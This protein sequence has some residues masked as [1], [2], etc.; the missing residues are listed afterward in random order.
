MAALKEQPTTDNLRLS[1]SFPH[2][3]IIHD[4]SLKIWD[5]QS[6]YLCVT[7][8]HADVLLRYFKSQDAQLLFYIWGSTSLFM[9]ANDEIYRLVY[10]EKTNTFSKSEL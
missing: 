7:P 10:D 3:A 4:D 6:G 1:D 5:D 2:H 9:L 8:S